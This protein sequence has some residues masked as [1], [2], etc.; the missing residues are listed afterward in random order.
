MPNATTA[1]WSHGTPRPP[2]PHLSPVTSRTTQPRQSPHLRA[3]VPSVPISARSES[4]FG[5]ATRAEGSRKAR[6]LS[7]KR[8]PLWPTHDP[9]NRG[10][11]TLA[12]EVT[13]VHPWRQS[14]PRP[15]PRPR[16]GGHP[17]TTSFRSVSLTRPPPRRAQPGG[18]LGHPGWQPSHERPSSPRKAG[19]Q[20]WAPTYTSPN[21]AGLCAPALPTL[22]KPDRRSVV[23]PRERTG[24]DARRW[25]S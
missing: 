7:H 3:P 10:A 11:R 4:Y 25:T 21:G 18:P 1:P 13:Y 9:P 6:G 23:T 17:L 2:S 15:A 19:P 14:S 12:I 5:S 22:R 8:S 16:A 20:V 24:A